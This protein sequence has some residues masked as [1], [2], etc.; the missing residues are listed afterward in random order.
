MSKKIAILTLPLHTNFGGNLQAFALQKILRDRGYDVETLDYRVRASSDA[1]KLLSQFKQKI[2]NNR[3]VYH[4]FNHEVK[5]IQINH[6]AFIEEN[7]KRSKVLTTVEELRKY[8]NERGFNYII[9]GSDQ[10]W[11]LPYSQR[12]YS[13]FLDFIDSEKITKISYAASF[14]VDYWEFNKVQTAYIANNLSKFDAISVRESSG[15]SLCQKYLSLT[16]EETLDPTLLLEVKD[17]LAL[18]KHEKSFTKG[19]ILSYILDNDGSKKLL[20]QDI[21]KQLNKEV[22]YIQP[23]NSQKDRL[24]IKDIDT[25]IYPKVET[26]L[27]GFMEADYV[28]TDSFHGTVFSI[29]FNKPFITVINKERGSARFYSLLKKFDLE[30]RLVQPDEKVNLILF[31]KIDY[32]KVN[33]I[34]SLYKEKSN[35]FLIESLTQENL[36]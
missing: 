21:A 12:V 8:I 7:I 29:I 24:I 22:V 33:E 5:A 31:E 10:V 23:I 27:K 15:V 9:V 26:W 32:Q 14:G 28:I 2:I 11:R 35:D 19:K 1:R 3:K 4:F 36:N 13:Y 6:Q 17:Y 20:E 16:V 18:C 25:Y 34:L 30:N